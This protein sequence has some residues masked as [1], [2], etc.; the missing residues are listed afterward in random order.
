MTQVGPT[1]SPASSREGGSRRLDT[2]VGQVTVGV[3]GWS[4]ARKRSQAKSAGGPQ[5]VEKARKRTVPRRLQRAPALPA[6]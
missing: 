3:R 5:K 2:E 1:R 6:P 4:D